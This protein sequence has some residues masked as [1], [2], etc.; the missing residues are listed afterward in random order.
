MENANWKFF[1]LS[2][3]GSVYFQTKLDVWIVYLS[4]AVNVI[5]SFTGI[6]GNLLI[7]VSFHRE[8]LPLHPPCKLLFRCLTSTDLCV[9]LI[10]QPCFVAYLIS[11]ARKSELNTCVFI[12]SFLTFFSALLCGISLCTLTIISVD[13]LLALLL[14]LRY[15]HVVT[16]ARVSGITFLSYFVLSSLTLV[17]FINTRI[18][19]TCMISNI[20]LCLAVSTSCYLKIY[21][22]IRRRQAL[23]R[24]GT[25]PGQFNGSNRV[26]ELR[27]KRSVSTSMLVS[28][29]M[30]ACYL[31]FTIFAAII[32]IGQELPSSFL[33]AISLVYFNSS[34]NPVIYCWR[35]REVKEAVKGTIRWFCFFYS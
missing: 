8:S 4:V 30:I 35:I 17:Y 15:R 12:T 28:I 11:V 23:V 22:G 9:G 21:F 27:Y 31:P 14:G 19:F 2:T 34:I 5:L 32:V 10:N 16:V 1:Q 33:A 3:C 26:R 25:T 13:R 7:L 29:F 18:F 20:L 6:I 24:Q